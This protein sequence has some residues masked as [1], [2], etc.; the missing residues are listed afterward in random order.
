MLGFLGEIWRFPRILLG[1]LIDLMIETLEDWD[2]LRKMVCVVE[3][4]GEKNG[5][6]MGR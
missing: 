6:S 5:A 4:H 2:F 1:D 3:F